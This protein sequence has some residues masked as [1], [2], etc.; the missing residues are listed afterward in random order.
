VIKHARVESF[1]TFR[2]RAALVEALMGFQFNHVGGG[3]KTRRPIALHMTYNAV[4]K[5]PQCFL[6]TET[7]T[8]K[9]MS[10]DELREYIEAENQRLSAEN[11][12]SNKDITIKISYKFCPNLTIV[13]TPGK[14]SVSLRIVV[15]SISMLFSKSFSIENPAP[16]RF[17]PGILFLF[18]SKPC[19]ALTYV[20]RLRELNSPTSPQVGHS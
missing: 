13:D 6:L 20:T 8:E 3:T 7:G 18:F 1:L 2:A 19:T 4:C 14:L 5:D 15:A 16:T 11:R 17:F 10:L 9:E 12:F